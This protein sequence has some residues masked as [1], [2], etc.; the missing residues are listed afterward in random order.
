MQDGGEEAP[1]FNAILIIA[2]RWHAVV[3][4]ACVLTIS[5][6]PLTPIQTHQRAAGKKRE[7]GRFESEHER[8]CRGAIL[9]R[10]GERCTMKFFGEFLHFNLKGET[11]QQSFNQVS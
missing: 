3:T 4:G 8:D 5:K 2:S 6:F 9:E 1:R 7:G 10:N 11:M